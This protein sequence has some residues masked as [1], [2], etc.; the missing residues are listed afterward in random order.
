MPIT[1]K[2]GA[3]LP[4][5]RLDERGELLLERLAR[6]G[7]HAQ[8]V[9]SDEPG[10]HLADR[11][12]AHAQALGQAR[13]DH[14]LTLAVHVPDHHEVLGRRARWLGARYLG[15]RHRPILEGPGVSSFAEPA[16]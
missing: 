13:G 7:V 8:Q 2:T 16:D 12:R 6:L 14:R 5:H 1:R 9:L 15:L 10:H 4:A 3:G 11:R